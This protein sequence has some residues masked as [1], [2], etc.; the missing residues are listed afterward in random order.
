MPRIF[1]TI[2]LIGIAFV[3]GLLYQRGIYADQCLDRGGRMDDG[4][5]FGD[6]GS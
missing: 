6:G 5:C 2:I 1:R 3:A 4:I